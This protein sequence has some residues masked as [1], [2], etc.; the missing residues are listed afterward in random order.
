MNRHC[1]LIAA[2]LLLS[3]HPI[4]AQ[5]FEKINL[6]NAIVTQAKVTFDGTRMVFMANY[7]GR[8]KPY[9]ADYETD[10]ARW[11]DPV[12]IFDA[13]TNGQYE[14]QYPQLNFDN[15]RLL[16]SA[17]PQ[18]KPDFDIYSSELTRGTWFDPV[19]LENGINSDRDDL[20]PS[21]SSDGKK[22]LFTR[23]FAAEEKK[24]VF[25]QEI[26]MI[27]KDETGQWLAP[28]ALAPTYNTGCVCDP[29]FARDNKTFFYASYEDV[30]DAEGRRVSRNQ[31]NIYWAKSDGVRSYTPKLVSSIQ[32]DADIRSLSIAGDSTLYYTYGDITSDNQ[33]R[34]SSN[35]R[36]GP[37]ESSLQ[38]EA[39]TCLSGTV[40]KSG[41]AVD[42]NVRVVDPFT[43]QAYQDII[44]D[45]N[46]YYQL[47]LPRDRQFSVLATKEGLSLQSQLIATD[48]EEMEVDFELF[49]AVKTSFNVFDEEF[50]FPIFTIITIY[51][52]TYNQLAQVGSNGNVVLDIGQELNVVFSADNYWEDTLSLPL[53]QEVLFENFDFDI[54]LRRKVKSVDLTFEDEETGNSLGLELTVLNVTR[55]EKT[56]RQVKGGKITLEL[57]D[58]EVYEISTSAQ[59]Y[60]YFNAEID[61][62]KEE[63]V[64][65]VKAELKSVKNQAIV[66][67][68]ITFEVN[69]YNLGA[70]SYEELDK[71]VTYL[72]E[73]PDYRV[74]VAAHTDDVGGEE[75]N[76]TLSNL[77]AN[78]VLEYLQDH[79]ITVERLVAQGYGESTPLF[80]NDTDT[81]RAKNRRVE[82]K[83]LSEGE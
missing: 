53:D 59:G 28:R 77:R 14:F 55:N 21:E 83:I 44:C 68:N 3:I 74:E 61:L 4:L 76:L 54:V 65:E 8:L 47:Y 23:P 60:S 41:S 70:Q 51:D 10:S 80:P 9:I 43:A 46:G 7:D 64:K 69:S 34:W 56:K 66:L 67:N 22:I 19:L 1:L 40:T 12:L 5:E 63:P 20:A 25:C 73:N 45:E 6:P 2:I 24:D 57:R 58:G 17:R 30:N 78:S 79:A 39:M 36:G 16:I 37:L 48:V 62:T 42:A 49:E 35:M 38:P 75:F 15:S 52:S 33:R 71:L 27:E 31:F 13:T 29:F 50:F 81:N 18:G 72:L 82:F 32:T 11:G 26:Y